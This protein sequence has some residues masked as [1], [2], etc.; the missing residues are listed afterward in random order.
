MD[1]DIGS[2]RGAGG[3][4]VRQWR[5]ERRQAGAQDRRGSETC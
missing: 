4:G 3:R 2:T 5:E 1:R